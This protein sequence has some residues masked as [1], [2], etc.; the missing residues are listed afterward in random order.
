MNINIK[1]QISYNIN[2]IQVECKTKMIAVIRGA[3]GIILK[4]F[5]IVSEQHKGTA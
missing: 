4:S 5:R 2:T 3:T 1:I